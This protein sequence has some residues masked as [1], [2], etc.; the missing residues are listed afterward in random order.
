M[1]SGH[2]ALPM[3]Q[4]A[5]K[6]TIEKQYHMSPT[7]FNGFRNR[8]PAHSLHIPPTVAQKSLLQLVMLFALLLTRHRIHCFTKVVLQ[9]RYHVVARSLNLSH[10]AGVS[11]R[12]HFKPSNQTVSM[13]RRSLIRTVPP[14]TFY[15][16]SFPPQ[17]SPSLLTNSHLHRH[18]L[19]G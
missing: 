8:D 12:R 5:H 9:G 1:T 3:L 7:Y 2:L 16:D 13:C 11:T 6:S 17:N 15:S 19:S 18:I 10:T 14:R 4:M